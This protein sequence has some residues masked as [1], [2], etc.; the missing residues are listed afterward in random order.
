MKKVYFT[1]IKKVDDASSE[2]SAD[3]CEKEVEKEK[4][5]IKKVRPT[6]IIDILE[7]KNAKILKKRSLLSCKDETQNKG[8]F[9]EKSSKVRSCQ[10]LPVSNY[11]F[12]EEETEICY[13]NNAMKNEE[14]IIKVQEQNDCEYRKKSKKSITDFSKLKLKF[15]C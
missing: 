12:F 15:D 7:R 10:N 6:L 5:E 8:S 1:K 11:V 3:S 9:I 13:E 2:I 4:T 14:T